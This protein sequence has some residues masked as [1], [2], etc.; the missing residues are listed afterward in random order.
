MAEKNN[1]PAKAKKMICITR[2]TCSSRESACGRR[3]F[4][5]ARLVGEVSAPGTRRR[6]RGHT[7]VRRGHFGDREHR[8]LG[9]GNSFLASWNPGLREIDAVLQMGIVASWV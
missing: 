4:V 5:D 9:H 3:D 8:R 7:L 2:M 1:T 6:Y